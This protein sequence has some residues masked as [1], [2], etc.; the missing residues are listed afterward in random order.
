MSSVTN[1]SEMR[2]AIVMMIVSIACLRRMFNM[3][4]LGSDM[5]TPS[6]RPRG[7]IVTLCNGC[8]CWSRTFRPATRND[9]DLVQRMRVLEQNIHERVA[10]FVPGGRAFFL[11]AHRHAAAFA[12]PADFVASLDR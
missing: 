10:G 6:A 11:V 4:S 12:A 8:A 5:V 3:S 1:C 2:P 9:R 7:M